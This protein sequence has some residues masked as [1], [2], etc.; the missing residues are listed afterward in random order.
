MI[1]DDDQKSKAA[2]GMLMC[3]LPII[4]AVVLRP[5]IGEFTPKNGTVD[6]LNMYH[7]ENSFWGFHPKKRDCRPTKY[8]PTL[9]FSQQFQHFALREIPVIY[10]ILLTVT[11]HY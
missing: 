4:V 5:E 7:L 8:V 11:A 9:P 10:N 2:A 1:K 6:L 3:L